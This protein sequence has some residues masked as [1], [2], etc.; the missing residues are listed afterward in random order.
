MCKVK[1]EVGAPF[2]VISLNYQKVPLPPQRAGEDV[3]LGALFS[4][5]SSSSSLSSFCCI[6]LSCFHLVQGLGPRGASWLKG[7]LV[8]AGRGSGRSHTPGGA[9]G[10]LEG[11]WAPQAPGPAWGA[12][13][14]GGSQVSP[15]LMCFTCSP[16]TRLSRKSQS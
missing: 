1:R 13:D 6:K 11:L 10:P 12:P 15:I 8:T 14:C 4:S 16:W 3:M 9:E 2:H 7:C 5:S